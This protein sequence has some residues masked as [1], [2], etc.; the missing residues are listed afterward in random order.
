MGAPS[1][2][3][4]LKITGPCGFARDRQGFLYFSNGF[5]KIRVWDGITTAAFTAGIKTPNSSTTPGI[6]ADGSGGSMSVG[7]YIFAYQYVDLYGRKSELSAATS[8]SVLANDRVDWTLVA[9]GETDR[10]RWVDLYRS[11]SGQS[12][13]VYRVVRLANH[14]TITGTA[15]NGSGFCQFTSSSGHGL[16]TNAVIT[17]AAHS[18]AGYNGSHTVTRISDTVFDTNV[19][20]TTAGTGTGTFTLTGYLNDG[21]SD[22]TLDDGVSL[23]ILNTDGSLNARR[24]GLPPPECA[25]MAWFQDRMYYAV[26]RRYSQGAVT[27]TANSTTI[28]GVTHPTTALGTEWIEEFG[29]FGNYYKTTSTSYSNW[30]MQIAGEPRPI[31]I[32]AFNSATSLVAISP[33]HPTL[34]QTA[35]NYVIYP[36]PDI[37]RN[38]I[39]YSEVDEGESV[40]Y[41]QTLVEGKV[42]GYVN[43]V[44]IQENTGDDDEITGLMPYGYALYVLKERH[45][46]RL[47]NVANDPSVYMLTARGCV[48]NR[49]WCYHD[50]LAYLMDK[51]GIYAFDGQNVDPIS[52][53]IQNLWI[54]STINFN[55]AHW[56]FASVDP[57]NEVVRFHVRYTGDAGEKPIRALCY[58]TRYKGWWLETYPWQLGGACK[59]DINN[60][61]RLLVGGVDEQIWKTNEGFTDGGETISYVWRSGMFPVVRTPAQQSVAF[62]VAFEPTTVATTLNARIYDDNSATAVTAEITRADDKGISVT[63]GSSNMAIAMASTHAGWVRQEVGGRG[64]NDVRG[65]RWLSLE[66]VGDAPS[67]QQVEIYG[68]LLEGVQGR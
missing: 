35:A 15:D 21:M 47:Q 25:V 7:A 63:A 65:R 19:A 17:I 64:T 59:A 68:V 9:S 61:E 8:L 32:G 1:I 62:E 20:F 60:V 24:Q 42:V 57:T 37:F 33:D 23:P 36:D 50:G 26:Q 38:T 14:G 18:V 13:T 51:S 48:N 29:T 40:P 55:Y 56:F 10:V 46:Y 66:L 34:T 6:T 31:R 43:T 16:Q 4:G 54:D 27:T 22:A 52:L 28:T 30:L 2:A 41:D 5:N 3:T 45:I 67:T 58:H 39:L 11:T 53:P 44:T 49:T 12:T